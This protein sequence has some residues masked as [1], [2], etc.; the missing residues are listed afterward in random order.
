M[1][2]AKCQKSLRFFLS[3]LLELTSI[4][5]YNYLKEGNDYMSLGEKISDLRKKERLSQEGLAEKIDVTRQTISNWEL[6]SS[7]PN[8][9]QLKKLSRIFNTS[10]DN[11]LDNSVTNKEKN[12]GY[13]YISKTKIKGIPLV[14]INLALGHGIKKAKGIIAI[15]DVA[16]GIIALG[17]VSIGVLTLGGLSLGLISLGG[18]ALGL[19]LAL[20]GI[21][22]GLLSLGGIAIGYFSIGGFSLGI[23]SIGGISIAKNVACGDY[24][25]GHVAIGNHVRGTVELLQY[26]TSSKEIENAILANFPKTW[27]FIVYLLSH[28][29]Y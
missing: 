5:R 26:K 6:N 10:I 23:Y 19:L 4:I 2:F 12:Y 24:A 21:A 8:P 9:E 28:V 18:L 3:I 29:V 1:R 25:Y 22:M 15:G 13:E 7:S 14:H 16:T 20:G 11:L 17:G 27:K